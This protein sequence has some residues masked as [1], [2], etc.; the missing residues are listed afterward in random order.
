M[1]SANRKDKTRMPKVI[2]DFADVFDALVLLGKCKAFKLVD[3]DT[4]PFLYGDCRIDTE[5]GLVG[6]RSRGMEGRHIC[7]DFAFASASSRR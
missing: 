7:P 4:V 3:G 6:C 1:R 2:Y 5:Y